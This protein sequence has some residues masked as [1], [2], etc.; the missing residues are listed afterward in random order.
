VPINQLKETK[1][2]KEI[3]EEESAVDLEEVAAVVEDAEEEVKVKEVLLGVVEEAGV[4]DVEQR[5]KV[6]SGIL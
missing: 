2:I 5:T 4:Q 6:E 3:K 1:E